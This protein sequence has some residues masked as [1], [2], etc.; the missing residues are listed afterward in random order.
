[1]SLNLRIAVRWL[2]TLPKGEPLVTPAAFARWAE[3]SHSVRRAD[4]HGRRMSDEAVLAFVRQAVR[5]EP[6]LTH[7]RALRLLRGSGN[8]CEQSRFRE[9][10]RDAA[11]VRA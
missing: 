6:R 2:E 11:G 9:L 7:S 3:W 10:F 8:A 1:M 5:S 4:P